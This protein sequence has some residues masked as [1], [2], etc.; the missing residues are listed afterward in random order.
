MTQMLNPLK[1]PLGDYVSTPVTEALA[2]KFDWYLEAVL[3]TQKCLMS[4]A[5]ADHLAG[6]SE[7]Y[8]ITDSLHCI[9][10]D[11]LL[12]AELSDAIVRIANEDPNTALADLLRA[13]ADMIA[14]DIAASQN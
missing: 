7:H 2:K 6:G 11:C 14:N 10:P 1:R 12:E 13:L 4:A 5:I 8:K 3:P 9:D